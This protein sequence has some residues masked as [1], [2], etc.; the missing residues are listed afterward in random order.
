MTRRVRNYTG[1]HR[2]LAQDLTFAIDELV[3][4]AIRALS[5]AINDTFTALT[6]IDWLVDA[7]CRISARWNP[8]ADSP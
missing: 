1:P 3:E 6:C 4:I 8:A 5:P 7:L 2:T